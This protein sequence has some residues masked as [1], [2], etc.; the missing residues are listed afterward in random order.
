MNGT[1]T[2]LLLA[3]IKTKGKEKEENKN[4]GSTIKW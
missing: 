3:G 4:K 1:G 2:K